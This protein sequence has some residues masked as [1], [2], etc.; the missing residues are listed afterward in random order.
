[1]RSAKWTKFAVMGA[2]MAV[3]GTAVALA[4]TKLEV[5]GVHLCCGACVKGVGA[6]LKGIEGVTPKCDQKARTITLTCKDDEAAQKAV[7]ALAEAGYH[8]DTGNKAITIKETAD[9]P[10]EN[11]KTLKLKGVH[12]CCG[13]CCKAI[14]TAVRSVPG[15]MDETA[16]PK[17]SSFQ[18][19]GDFDAAAVIKALND[20]GFHVAVEK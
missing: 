11:V 20:A 18:V 14:K 13:A 7:N 12:N 17:Q 8:G 15:I 9:V 2:L 5:K 19:S 4:E 16:M 3:T 1:M 6:A 10:S